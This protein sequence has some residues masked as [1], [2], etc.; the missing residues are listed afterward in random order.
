MSLGSWLILSFWS[1]IDLFRPWLCSS[2]NYVAQFVCFPF[3]AWNWD[4]IHLYFPFIFYED[5]L[6]RLQKNPLR[7]YYDR[8]SLLFTSV[9]SIPW[10]QTNLLSGY[11]YKSPSCFSPS[12]SKSISSVLSNQKPASFAANL[13]YAQPQ[14]LHLDYISTT[15]FK[16]RLSWADCYHFC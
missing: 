4:M 16:L 7:I 5:L 9:F 10:V 8:L 1:A 11:I 14:A 6:C 15:I 3:L 2:D 12:S 13:F